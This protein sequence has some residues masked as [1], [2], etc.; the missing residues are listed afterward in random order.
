MCATSNGH[1]DRYCAAHLGRR[2]APNIP[3]GRVTSYFLGNVHLGTVP[4]SLHRN[5]CALG[6]NLR[7]VPSISSSAGCQVVWRL[8]NSMTK[9]PSA[10]ASADGISVQLLDC[11]GR[12]QMFPHVLSHNNTNSLLQDKIS[13]GTSARL[14][15]KTAWRGSFLPSV[16]LFSFSH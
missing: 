4:R 1:V 15:R 10:T 8:T 6:V 13:H 5:C 2:H 9:T 11:R 14:Y 12:S 3:A 16:L 7:L